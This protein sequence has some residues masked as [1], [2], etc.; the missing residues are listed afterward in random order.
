MAAELRETSRCPNSRGPGHDKCH[1]SRQTTARVMDMLVRSRASLPCRN[2]WS[3]WRR[4]SGDDV[5][6]LWGF[7][8]DAAV[9]KM[10]RQGTAMTTVS[11]RGEVWLGCQNFAEDS[12]GSGSG[13]GLLARRPGG[14]VKWRLGQYARGGKGYL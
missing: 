5:D 12:N 3:Q 10:V 6:V 4:G 13:I 14:D 9:G 1:G 2:Q 8:G 11:T 7:F